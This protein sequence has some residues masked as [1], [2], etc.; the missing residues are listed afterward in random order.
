MQHRLILL[1]ILGWIPFCAQA[2]LGGSS[3]YSFLD[4]PSSARATALGGAFYASPKGDIGLAISNPSL[5]GKETHQQISFNTGLYLAGTNFGT[6]AYGHFSEKLKTAFSASASYTTYGKFDG[7]DP[8]GNPI[9]DFRA[10]NFVLAGGAARD[11]KKFT[12]GAQLKLIFSS[13]EQYNS[14]G[15]GLDLS[16]GY[17]NEDKN[18]VITM[19]L[20]NIGAEFKS[21]VPGTDRE[22][23]PLDLSFGISKRFDKLPIRLNFAGHHLQKWDLTSPKKTN[24][25]QVIGGSST[26]ERGFIDKL[27]AHVLFGVE[28]EAGKVVR[29]R[30]GYDHLRR[31]EL[32]TGDKKGL[33]G[34]SAGVG[35]V[36]KQF[37]IDYTF[38]K[39]H[40]VGALNQIGFAVNLS[41]WGNQTN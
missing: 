37:R 22:N 25:Q 14:L 4:L 41:D 11:W 28:V 12:Y 2:Q 8:A 5:L 32:A 15:L 13:I 27:F 9:G 6:A 24:S 20:R 34:M 18:L 29:L 38:A 3:T 33:V 7:R 39:Y 35:V 17:F 40:T 36:V 23:L 10:G 21:Y 31:M 26:K 30:V 16:A 19:L 1:I